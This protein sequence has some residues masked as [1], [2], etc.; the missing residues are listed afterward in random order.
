MDKRDL[1][2]TYFKAYEVQPKPLVSDLLDQ[3]VDVELDRAEDIEWKNDC[4]VYFNLKGYQRVHV[5]IEA[6][7]KNLLFIEPNSL[8]IIERESM[9]GINTE[10]KL[11]C[12][13]KTHL[14]RIPWKGYR[15]LRKKYRAF[16]DVI[17]RH[18]QQMIQKLM[19]RCISLSYLS[20][21]ERFRQLMNKKLY[22]L[23]H[24]P[25]KHIASYLNIHPTNF[26]TL[27]SKIKIT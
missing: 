15:Y 13:S 8:N 25:H 4:Y 20:M 6:K 12:I 10:V 7:E 19:N 5:E 27:L 16:E 21:E 11:S 22:L 23:Q 3:S 1:L 18:Q 24:I 26:S 17:L 9:P 14:L 2:L